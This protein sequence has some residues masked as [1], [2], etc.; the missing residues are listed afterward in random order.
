MIFSKEML[1]LS[2]FLILAFLFFMGS[3]IG[4]VL[5]L[6]FR[7]FFSKANPEHKWLNPGFCAGPYLPI[8]GVGLCLMYLIASLE[9]YSTV[10][11]P[12]WNK[13]LLFAL[14]AVCMTV[15]EYIAG[16][17]MLKIIKVRLW[18]YSGEWGNIGG[19][20]CPKFSFFWAVLG[21]IYYF[22]IH[23]HILGALEWLSDNLAFS[24]VIGFF[25]GI[26]LLDA[27]HSVQFT[28]KL[29][30]FAEEN[31]VIVRYENLKA[32]IRSFHDK[33]AKKSH[34]L[35]AFRSEKPFSEYMKEFREDFETRI[36]K[37][38]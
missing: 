34:F 33:N 23:P 35:F 25:F 11:N 20:I 37:K 38:K 5:E 3:T 36:R 29:K 14:M 9:R 12:F 26:F 22:L 8:Y 15:I 16:V 7:R 6:F 27:A 13:V 30:R 4:W 21:A 18:D 32:Q 24:F 31:D 19:I 28:A 10:E 1:I 2:I 17:W